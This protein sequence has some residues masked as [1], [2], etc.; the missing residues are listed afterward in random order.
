MPT[1]TIANLNIRTVAGS[2]DR[3][4]YLL[5]PFDRLEEWIERTAPEFGVS[6]AVVTGM[7]WDNDLGHIQGGKSYKT[8]VLQHPP[9]SRCKPVQALTPPIR[10]F[11]EKNFAT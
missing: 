7:D 6:I 8:G 5:Y 9:P 11:F 10:I 2:P 1:F 3:I 4:C